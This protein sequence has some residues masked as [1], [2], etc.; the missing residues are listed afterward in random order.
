M[1][2]VISGQLSKTGIAN[3]TRVVNAS[4]KIIKLIGPKG[5]AVLAN[6]FRSGKNIYGAAAMKNVSKLLR[7]NALTGLVSFAVLSSFDVANIFRGRISGKQLFKNMAQTGASIGGGAAG[8]VAGAKAGALIGTAAIPIPV[9]GTIIGILS[10]IIVGGVA[11]K[12]VK[13]TLD[14]FIED[15]AVAMEKILNEVFT[16]LAE[17][18]LVSKEEAT[19][20]A[21]EL[22]KKVTGKT[23]KDMFAAPNREYFADYLM[24]ENFDKMAAARP[25][26][27]L[28]SDDD[29]NNALRVVLDE[30]SDEL[31]IAN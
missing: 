11:S 21:E 5:A 17:D 7:N 12:V 3:A 29:I 8:F 1:S 13:K 28:P 19:K 2:A 18:Y 27:T 24:R 9:A 10:G 26:I 14:Q 22:G 20:L 16:Q 23:L 6:A 4:D 31:A 25:K 15:D 30:V